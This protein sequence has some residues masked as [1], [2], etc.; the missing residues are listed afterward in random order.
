MPLRGPMRWVARLGDAYV[1]LRLRRE[2]ETQHYLGPN[3]RAVELRF[4]F[5][6]V[7]RFAPRTVLDV[8]TGTT[9]LPALL[10]TCGCVVTAADNISDYWPDGMV[11][12]YYHVVNDD[13]RAPRLTQR[14]DMITCV[15]VLEHI[16]EHAEAVAGM[17][18]LLGPGGHLVLTCPY[19]DPAYCPDVYALPDSSVRIRYPFVTQSYSRCEVDGWL[20]RSGAE[21]IEQEFWQFFSGRFWTVGEP[22][23]P[24]RQVAR[25]DLHQITCLLLRKGAGATSS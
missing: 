3:E 15:S 9:A 2:F 8:G 4:V 24:P 23:T 21:L 17:F 5:Q 16:V 18:S 22:I 6:Q 7:A 20:Q 25:N 14:F 13:I 11:N 10:R 19:S 12:R 1:G